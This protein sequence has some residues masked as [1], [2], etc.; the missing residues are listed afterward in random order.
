ME[1]VTNDSSKTKVRRKWEEN[2][3]GTVV[4]QELVGS[5]TEERLVS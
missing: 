4:Q 5:I 2:E 1:Q 3:E